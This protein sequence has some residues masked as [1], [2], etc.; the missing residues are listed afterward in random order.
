MSPRILGHHDRR[1]LRQLRHDRRTIAMILV[2]PT[3]LLT[4]LYF[5][6]DGQERHLR[7]GRAD[8]A[9][10]LP[11]RH[12]VPGHQH[13]DAARAHHRHAGAAVHHAAGQ[14]GPAV[15]LRHRVRHRRRASRPRSRPASRTGSRPGHRGQ[16]V[17]GDPDR[18]RQ[19]RARRRARP[20]L[21]RVR[22]H[23]VPG[24]AVHAGGRRAAAAAVRAVR[25]RATRWPAG[26]RRS[27]TCCRCRTRSRR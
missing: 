20:A 27:A 3:V 6:F 14:A 10:R 5:M 23:R 1:I 13:R 17:A 24:R 12:H 22:P 9:R 7:P 4:L 16:P 19:R 21:Q 18:G 25:R 11:V 15:R 2:V 8:H 26:C